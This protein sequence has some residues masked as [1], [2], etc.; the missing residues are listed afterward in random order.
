MPRAF[1]G[2]STQ[3]TQS[4]IR[5]RG[6][7]FPEPRLHN[8]DHV[9]AQYLAL[10]D[11]VDVYDADGIVVLMLIHGSNV[12]SPQP[13]THL[14]DFVLFLYTEGLADVVFIAI[15][16]LIAC[17]SVSRPTETNDTVITV[18]ADDDCT[19]QVTIVPVSI[20]AN[21]FVVIFAKI[22]RSCGPTI[23]CRASLI[24]FMPYISNPSAPNSFSD[25]IK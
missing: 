22:C 13:L 12:L 10:I 9:V 21:R 4:I 11:E 15:I 18:V 2:Y 8:V 16:T 14:V 17:A 5:G 25:T 23:F 6:L 19:A 20:P 3:R 24:I 7:L 1:G